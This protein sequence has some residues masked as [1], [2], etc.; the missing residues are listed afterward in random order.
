[1]KYKK[2]FILI[3]LIALVLF[4]V[5]LYTMYSV[6]KEQ[7]IK[8]MNIN[9]TIHAKQAITGIE[10]YMANVTNTLNFLSR[11][12]EIIEIDDIGKRI[13]TNYQKLNSDEIKSITRVNAQGI[14]TYTVPFKKTIKKD[15]SYQEHVRLS[16]KTH[17]TVVSDVFMSVQGF[18]TVAVHVPVFKN[19]KYD[20]TIAFLLSFD[21]I[22]QKYIENIHIGT[23]GYAWVVSRKG[24]EISSP[25]PAHI[26]SYVYDTYKN[27]PGI[28]SMIGKMLKGKGG[29][30][31]YQYY[32]T[33][34][35]PN[36]IVLR[37]A[38]YMPI[39]FDNTYWSIVV[40]TPEDEVIASLSEFKTNLFLITIALFMIS[41]IGMYFI[42]RFQIII[43]EHK[44]RDVVLTALKE[45][46][47]RYRQLTELSPVGIAVL[48]DEK[49][50]FCNPEGANILGAVN[51]EEIVGKRIDEIIHPDKLPESNLRISKMLAGNK[52]LYPIENVYLKLDGTSIDVE[53][54]ATPFEYNGK[55]AMQVIVMDITERKRVEGQ[56]HNL[57]NRL[58]QSEELM[59][60][61]AA[62]QLHDQVGQNLTALT[63]NLSYIKTQLSVESK[64]KNEKRLNDSLGILNDTVDQ[65]RNI[66]VEL[67]PPILEDYGLNSAMSWSADKFGERTKIKVNYNGKDFSKR[68]PFNKESALFRVF[69]EILH[70]ITKHSNAKKVD[71]LLEEI[72]NKIKLIVKDDGIGFKVD[73]VLQKDEIKSFGL[74]SMT[75]RI[76]FIGGTLNVIS[77]PGK[78]TKIQI[79]IRR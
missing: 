73:E 14:I 59:R 77:K 7:T 50:V 71:I 39:N 28:I 2:Y 75:E 60:K 69:Q 49:I 35:S 65:I 22:A 46:E 66:M 54:M 64:V 78:G 40:S 13:I 43:R 25:I 31:V 26:G 21:R 61:S 47:D 34:N 19:G 27:F 18:R 79:E 1:M 57:M 36:D 68:L 5:A 23:S 72:N 45:S 9:Q 4:A 15:I 17:K 51:T 24:I 10:D 58:I 42:V 48:Q 56:L 70:N 16:M 53:V 20:G 33:L 11:L 12:P 6:V 8:N 67:Q 3:F 62:H 44:K 76:R 63:I 55:P 37:H 52:S 74:V 41:V 32:R 38:V 30:T 29:V